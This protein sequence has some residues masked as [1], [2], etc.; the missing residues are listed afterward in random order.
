MKDNM[1][2]DSVTSDEAC[3]SQ[4]TISTNMCDNYFI[5][6]LGG[7]NINVDEDNIASNKE[8]SSNLIDTCIEGANLPSA[9]TWKQRNEGAPSKSNRSGLIPKFPGSEEINP[10]MNKHNIEGNG[11][12]SMPCSSQTSRANPKTARC[13]FNNFS[14][15]LAPLLDQDSSSST[16]NSSQAS[17]DTSG[18]EMHIRHSFTYP[19]ELS[20]K[21]QTGDEDV[22]CQ[23]HTS[24]QPTNTFDK[25]DT[26]LK[27][28][29]RN[30]ERLKNM[31]RKARC[32]FMTLFIINV[33]LIICI[34]VTVPSLIIK[35][36][37]GLPDLPSETTKRPR[38]DEV[39]STD[40][41]ICFDCADLGGFDPNFTAETLSEMYRKGTSCCFKSITSVY[42]SLKQI[43][44]NQI[45]RKVNELNQTAN[46][47][48]N[49]LIINRN[50]NRQNYS[51]EYIV[52]RMILLDGPR[53]KTA[54]HLVSAKGSPVQE[55]TFSGLFNKLRWKGTSNRAII[56]G[57]AGVS[58]NGLNVQVQLEGYYFLYARLHFQ[59]KPGYRDVTVRYSI[60]RQRGSTST[61]IHEATE[62][63]KSRESSM[64]HNAVIEMII[65][66]SKYDEVFVSVSSSD[67][68]YLATESGAHMLGLFEL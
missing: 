43:F 5:S 39:A 40:Y 36:G 20:Y 65:H 68:E 51:T 41:N 26:D 1:R 30:L 18:Y 58:R 29:K 45:D 54:I 44:Q 32:I 21:S 3:L 53:E 25:T 38:T 50:S 8:V 47:I 22:S 59:S 64:E 46:F 9:N 6:K 7:N 67:M 16:D 55:E 60:N 42:L 13:D 10:S 61:Y 63:C 34:F 37:L 17:K 15:E 33:L 4:Q 49:N 14:L 24:M 35:S 66:L 11:L 19:Q 52:R 12:C 48:R 56:A 57:N 28:I 27:S 23:N 31:H 2:S 62:S